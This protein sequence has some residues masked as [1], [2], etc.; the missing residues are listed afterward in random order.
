MKRIFDSYKYFVNLQSVD[1]KIEFT[2]TKTNEAIRLKESSHSIINLY[3]KSVKRKFRSRIKP[4]NKRFKFATPDDKKANLDDSIVTDSM[5]NDQIDDSSAGDTTVVDVN[6]VEDG[7]VVQ[8]ETLD[9]IKVVTVR[10]ISLLK[11][12]RNLRKIK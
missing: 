10:D 12:I 7:N 11:R 4:E 3:S 5:L 2:N 9:D 1:I 6:P 8:I